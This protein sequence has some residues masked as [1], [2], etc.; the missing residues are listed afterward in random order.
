[1][2]DMDDK[3]WYYYQVLEI[4]GFYET[5]LIK[6]ISWGVE[7]KEDLCMVLEINEKR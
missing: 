2:N 6:K 7:F 5:L 3:N 4:L 1:M